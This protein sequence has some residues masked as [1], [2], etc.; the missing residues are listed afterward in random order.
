MKIVFWGTPKYALQSLNSI[1]NSKH[2][3]IA[4]VSQPDKRRG[5]GKSKTPSPVKEKALQLGLKIFTPNDIKRQ[6]DI[7]SE[8]GSLEA[9]IYIVV[10]FG[11][12]LPENIL[13]QPPLGCWNSHASLLPNWRGAGPI[14]W[15]LIEGE[16]KTGVSIMAMEKGLDTG[17]VLI[18]EKVDIDLLDNANT[19]AKKLSIL[20]GK[21]LIE[22]LKKIESAN[23]EGILN[24]ETKL[25]IKSQSSF[26]AEVTYAR[27][28]TKK[29]RLIEWHKTSKEIHCLIMGLYPD[30]HTYWEGK[31][32]KILKSIPL[33]DDYTQYLSNQIIQSSHNLKKDLPGEIISIFDSDGILVSTGESNILIVEAQLEG[34]KV[35]SS[36]RLIQ[37]IKP[38]IGKKLGY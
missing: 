17:P 33:I 2:E 37:Q 19:L 27:L 28:I 5:R 7:Q 16:K 3:L 36:K 20:S 9:D 8:I 30:A 38:I 24:K 1:V 29:D 14:Q 12:I 26:K 11:Q 34:K 15:S 10:A 22:S 35:S 23:H 21:L 32:L 4:V 6:K 25:A 13:N 18:Q 31:R